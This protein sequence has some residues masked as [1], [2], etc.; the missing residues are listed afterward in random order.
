MAIGKT[1]RSQTK[2]IK[3]RIT[4]LCQFKLQKKEQNMYLRMSGGNDFLS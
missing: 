1:D 2:K 4:K 3:K